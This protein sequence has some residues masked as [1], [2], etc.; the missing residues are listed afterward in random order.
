MIKDYLI[1]LA[2]L[3]ISFMEYSFLCP[4]DEIN[5]PFHIEVTGLPKLTQKESSEKYIFE[6]YEIGD[7]QIQFKYYKNIDTTDAAKVIADRM[8]FINSL[9][10]DQLS[11]Y[12]GVLSNTIGCSDEL[13]PKVSKSEMRV[14]Y[15]L[16]ATST[17]IYGNC[18]INDN[19]YYCLYSVFYCSQSQTLFEV[20]YYIPIKAGDFN[21]EQLRE[22]IRCKD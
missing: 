5:F 17:F 4:G 8:F 6:E 3:L 12:P 7:N 19:Y 1:P 20:K 18:D 22:S 14:D 11:P 13:K 10:K 16:L 15:K 21:Y 9:Y 2:F